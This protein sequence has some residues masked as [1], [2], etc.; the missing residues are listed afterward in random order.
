MT[1]SFRDGLHPG[2]FL[3]SYEKF[4][5]LLSTHIEGEKGEDMMRER[6]REEESNVTR[7]SY[8]LTCLATEF[9][10]KVSQIISNFLGCNEKP[11]SYV[12]TDVSFG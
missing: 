12:K 6:E 8:F 10:T 4:C 11:L 5:S 3:E 2:G 1:T 9:I 7:L